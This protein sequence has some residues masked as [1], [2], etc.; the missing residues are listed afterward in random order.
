MAFLVSGIAVLFVLVILGRAFVAA[1]PNALVR[2][3]RYTVG[4]GLIVIGMLLMLARR[5]EFALPLIAVGISALTLGR[6]GPIDLGGGRRSSGSA[7]T[8]RSAFF[9]M[10]LD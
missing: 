3:V 7:S 5:F 10:R 8:V 6:I 4:I 2:A 9:E 1:D